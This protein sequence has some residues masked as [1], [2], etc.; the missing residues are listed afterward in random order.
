MNAL[1]AL[2]AAARLRQ[3]IRPVEGFRTLGCRARFPRPA[4]WVG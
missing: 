1:N 3:P 4:G 2:D